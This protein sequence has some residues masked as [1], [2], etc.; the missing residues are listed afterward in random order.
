MNDQKNKQ[1]QPQQGKKQ[2]KEMN[3][4]GQK[5]TKQDQ[6]KQQDNPQDK[7]LGKQNKPHL[8]GEMNQP[9]QP[10]K[11]THI[12]DNPDETKKKIPNMENRH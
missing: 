3:Q 11:R 12:G 10:D 4:Q 6:D 9:D 2:D 1:Q 5:S 8:H 7:Q